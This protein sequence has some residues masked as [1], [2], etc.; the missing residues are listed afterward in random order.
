M[1]HRDL[2]DIFIKIEKKTAGRDWG[3]DGQ[4][5]ASCRSLLEALV[6]G[7]Q[8][9]AADPPVG[10]REGCQM[11]GVKRAQRRVRRRPARCVARAWRSDAE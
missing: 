6:G 3:R 7:Q 5:V 4:P 8:L 1:Y 10:R 11:Q 9:E 2:G